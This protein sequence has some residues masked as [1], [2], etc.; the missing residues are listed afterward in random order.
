MSDQ[1]PCPVEDCPYTGTLSGLRSHISMRDDDAHDW[2][3]VKAEVEEGFDTDTDDDDQD[4]EPTDDQDDQDD[5]KSTADEYAEQWSD[6]DQD[7][8]QD[9][10]GDEN[11]GRFG[12][13]VKWMLAA[14]AIVLVAVV[15]YLVLKRGG[16]GGEQAETNDPAGD[17]PE[18]GP[19]KQYDSPVAQ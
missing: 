13:P 11:G 16:D 19:G 5:E 12:V 9:A 14:G 18:G 3:D 8:D 2:E 6:D 15:A 10:D 1:Q 17:D 7:A 4:D